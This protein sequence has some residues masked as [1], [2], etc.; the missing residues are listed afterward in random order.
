MRFGN[1]LASIDVETTG[2]DPKYHEM[3]QIGIV[4]L[5]N[6][7]NPTEQRFSCR[8]KP[9][10][11]ERADPAATSVHGLSFDEGLDADKV[12]DLLEEWV[13]SLKMPVGR[14]LMP[15]AHNHLFE[16]GFLTAWLGR[17]AYNEL[18]GYHP[19][20]SMVLALM[21]NDQ[22]RLRGEPIPFE[23]VSLTELCKQF[24]IVNEKAHDALADSYAAAKVYKAL[25]CY[26]ST[27]PQPLL[28]GPSPVAPPDPT[29]KSPP[30]IEYSVH[31]AISTGGELAWNAGAVSDQTG[32]L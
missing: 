9:E 18:F 19:R 20:D 31:P 6:D 29:Q 4:I 21:L 28:I 30:S 22:A 1:L 5:D 8:I 10:R 24:N 23:S 25:L 14:K 2:T 11:P 16:Y 26:S 17:A 3:I 15:L 7:L 27:T 32:S 12:A 13:A